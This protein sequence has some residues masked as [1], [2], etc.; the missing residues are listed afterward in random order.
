MQNEVIRGVDYDWVVEV[1][2]E[3]NPHVESAGG[4]FA[5]FTFKHPIYAIAATVYS[6]AYIPLS[7]DSYVS[8]REPSFEGTSDV[9]PFRLKTRKPETR[10]RPR[11]AYSPNSYDRIISPVSFGGSMLQSNFQDFFREDKKLMLLPGGLGGERSQEKLEQIP[12]EELRRMNYVFLPVLEGEGAGKL[13]ESFFEYLTALHFIEKGYITTFY[14]GMHQHG[15]ADLFAYRIPEIAQEYGG[16]FAVELLFDFDGGGFGSEVSEMSYTVEVEPTDQRVLSTG[17]SGIGQVK[18]QKYYR[19][20]SGG[21]SA[22]PAS[23]TRSEPR[24]GT[25][26]YNENCRKL[27]EEPK[28]THETDEKVLRGFRE[29]AKFLLLD[30]EYERLASERESLFSYINSLR[31][32]DLEEL[33]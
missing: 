27:C 26:V 2:E 21:F 20:F 17:S 6:S 3:H 23:S 13:G 18:N 30:G 28:E 32:N 16:G 14:G 22:G 4:K 24:V 15:F 33:L 9:S 1:L 5:E 11:G 7:E 19:G 8:F 10:T 31:E 12:D 25:I 29:Y